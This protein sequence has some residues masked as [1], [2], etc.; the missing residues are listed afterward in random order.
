MKKL[1][2]KNLKSFDFPSHFNTK[3]AFAKKKA[4]I[5]KLETLIFLDK[6]LWNIA[7]RAFI[8]RYIKA[9]WLLSPIE[10]RLLPSLPFIEYPCKLLPKKKEEKN[11]RKTNCEIHP[12]P[13]NAIALKATHYTKTHIEIVNEKFW[14]K[15]RV[16]SVI[17]FEFL[18]KIHTNTLNLG[19]KKRPN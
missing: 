13:E 18:A 15:F 14:Q 4:S 11:T 10:H 6:I 2:L 19:P 7:F 5:R 16:N 12:L 3:I 17:S 1:L 8:T 9:L